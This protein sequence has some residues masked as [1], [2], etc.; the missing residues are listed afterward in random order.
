[1]KEKAET[2]IRPYG[3]RAGKI[4]DS[5]PPMAERLTANQAGRRR[6]AARCAMMS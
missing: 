6:D 3:V 5:A 1:M 4:N 2:D